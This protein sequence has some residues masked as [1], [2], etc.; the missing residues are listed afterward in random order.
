M[1]QLL[2]MGRFMCLEYIARCSG[3]VMSPTDPVAHLLAPI[4]LVLG[5][6]KRL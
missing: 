3:E 6:L 5:F 2:T 1:T 4:S